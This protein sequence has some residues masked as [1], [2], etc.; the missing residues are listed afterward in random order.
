MLLILIL[1]LILAILKMPWN[2]GGCLFLVYHV[3]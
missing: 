1:D 2:N 3:R